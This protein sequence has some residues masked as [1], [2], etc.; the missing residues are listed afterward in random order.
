MTAARRGREKRRE[1]LAAQEAAAAA[2][3]RARRRSRW[4]RI[5]LALCAAVV[6]AALGLA[7][8]APVQRWRTGRHF[9]EAQRLL[10]AGRDPAAA[11]ELALVLRRDPSHGKARLALADLELRRGRIEHG[12]LHLVSYT[13]LAPE[14]AG[15]WVRL[16]DLHA[17]LG[18]PAEVEAALT[19]ALE[20]E[21]GKQGL[22]SRRAEVR[23]RLGRFR[24]ALA[25]AEIAVRADPGDV[26]AWIVLS[27]AVAAVR[28]PAAGSET[29]RR[30]IAAAGGDPRLLALA[31]QG[32]PAQASQ[33]AS[34]PV[35]VGQAESWPGDLGVKAREF[36]L[37][38]RQA[39]W[40]GAAA[41]ARAARERYPGT[42]LG[43]W[44]EGIAA[45]GEGQP[46]RG[47]QALLEALAVSPRSHRAVTNLIGLWSRQK[48]P[49]YTGDRLVALAERDPG[50]TYPLPIA[51]HAYLEAAQPA[52]AEATI[53]RLFALLPSSPIP[54]RETAEFFL[55]VDRASDAMATCAQGLSRFSR[56]ADLQLLLAR[57]ALS[58]GDRERAIA[59]YED[60]LA[61]RP[62]SAVAAA[63][64]ARLLATARKD[65]PSRE[66]ALRLVRELELDL[67]AD[68]EVLTAM[69]AV[70]LG[71]GGD[72]RRARLW[73][74]AA[75]QA[76]PEEP[77]V[78]YQLALAY[79][80]AGETAL[81]R[82]EIG[83]ALKSGR[84][85]AE[86][87]EARRLAR[88]L[89]DAP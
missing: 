3:T 66:R 88:E 82:K 89:G 54:F 60:A 85:F 30:A 48:G 24:S 22:A 53:R 69:G 27:R 6:L 23:L 79:A 80:R 86:E 39:N 11:E 9:A 51:A 70:L 42:L 35:A 7:A 77:G 12:F 61:A 50:F 34:R 40:S 78:R 57:A 81:A 4:R 2:E 73:L 58:L 72:A 43:P 32:P 1:A 20:A 76:A 56:D 44:L 15:G 41:L 8:Q 65:G 19:H 13:E 87:P 5:A 28:G 17:T 31:G 10:A 46:E 68:P 63:Q 33:P 14:D 71:P 26:G 83:E 37:L 47:E 21:P 64:L 36:R 38:S 55:A 49:E 25:D 84:A 45:L 16:A 59:A 18:Q 29:V 52:K 74:E 62:D 75:R 67:P